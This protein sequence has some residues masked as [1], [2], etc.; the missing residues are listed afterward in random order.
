[1][2]FLPSPHSFLNGDRVNDS[3]QLLN[4]AKKIK[5]TLSMETVRNAYYDWKE[6]VTMMETVEKGASDLSFLQS[7]CFRTTLLSL[8]TKHQLRAN[9][10]Q[11]E[12]NSRTVVSSDK[13]HTHIHH[14]PFET[15]VSTNWMNLSSSLLSSTISTETS[16]PSH[17]LSS[18]DHRTASTDSSGL[19]STISTKTSLPS[20]LLSS[21]DHR[22]SSTDS[23]GLSSTLSTKTSRPSQQSSSPSQHVSSEQL[24]FQSDS[25]VRHSRQ[26][27]SSI[28]LILTR[29]PPPSFPW[30]IP[31]S[32][33]SESELD[34]HIQPT[35][36]FVDQN[37]KFDTSVF[38]ETDD[39]SLVASLRRCRVVVETTHSTQCIV[40]VDT[41]RTLLVSG[42][43][44]SN[45]TVQFE[46]CDLF[47]E[48]RQLR[49]IADD[50][51]E[52]RLQSLQKAFRDGTFWEK[53]TLLIL[54]G[55]WYDNKAQKGH[56]QMMVESDFDFDGF[57]SADLS[58]T[59]LFDTACIFVGKVIYSAEVL[60][61]HRW[62]MDFLLSFEKR[63][64]MM[65]RLSSDPSPSS[66]QKRSS[67]FLSPAAAGLGLLLSVFR[68]YCFPSALTELITTDL[69]PNPT[70]YSRG[71][72]PAYFFNHTSIAP[73]H[74]HSFF[75]M[76]LMFERFL[77]ND[78]DAFF[79]GRPRM[80]DLPSRK[81]LFTHSV[82]L[83]ALLRR[84]PQ[85]NLN[86]TGL[87]NLIIML[88]V[89]IL[90]QE[91][92]QD[93]IYKLFAN[94]PPPRLFNTLLSS[95]PNV[96]ATKILWVHFLL[97]FTSF[98]LFTE[99][100]GACSSLAKVFKLLIRFEKEFDEIERKL[101]RRAGDV[102]VSLHWLSIPAPFDSPLLCHL[103]SL[104][105]AQRGLLQTLSSHSGIPSL[106]RQH[107]FESS[108]SNLITGLNEGWFFS[109]RV[110][111]LSLYVRHLN[112]IEFD[113]STIGRWHMNFITQ[114]LLHPAPAL[115]SAAFEFFH[116]FVSV[117]SDAVRMELV[118]KGLLDHVVFA[119]SNSSYM[120]VYTNQC[121][122]TG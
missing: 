76:D 101:L 55:L 93:E 111:L 79:D 60:M 7:R 71:V 116:R 56:R 17:L 21:L 104:A 109:S 77:R 31:R 50:P 22:T 23:S 43:H 115:V 114:H 80:D 57:L 15:D 36:H 51:R 20:H 107:R 98:S 94:F 1:M 120:D 58:D 72:N 78:P 91:I 32:F 24:I 75:P 110:H 89:M 53:M 86:Q 103:P 99:P 64:R 8:Q 73:K 119:V 118:K 102:V 65:S 48:I 63:H 97:F 47:L 52:R 41:F 45:L 33:K 117:S 81:F 113:S 108:L 13:I 34:A 92:T 18:L 96:R 27:L 29:P 26:T 39:M 44:S 11:T 84:C 6:W 4:V 40:D 87:H 74:R 62:K 9:P 83:H 112:S 106:A 25:L 5:E 19:S 61:S 14:L 88:V 59:N 100:F 10:P 46:C 70:T 67:L 2:S 105:G 49:P 35:P 54:W 122:S 3:Q 85:L 82:G 68:G 95:P 30:S 37:E 90:H 42:L 38:D 69:D 66:G 28:H 121:S 16:L 12:E